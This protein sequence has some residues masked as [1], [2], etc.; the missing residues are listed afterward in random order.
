MIERPRVG[1]P[2]RIGPEGDL[3][4]FVMDEQDAV[5]I[6][7]AR[8]TSLAEAVLRAEGVR[9]AAE[10]S[11]AFV[12]EADIADL[13]QR[14]MGAEGPTDVLAF[15]IDTLDDADG[16]PV[17]VR[18]GESTG[19]DRPPGDPGDLPLLL[20]DVVVCPAVAGRNAPTHAGTLD[21]E[22]ALL[23]VHGTLHVLGYDHAEPEE[24][25]RMRARERELLEAHHWGGPAPVGFRQVHEDEA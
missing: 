18:A 12:A 25:E 17:T 11:V 20:G 5:A 13:N 14:F 21:D 4:V 19:P 1:G 22:L 8:W 23:V 24:T 7:V 16:D 2:H 9:G 6:D 10:L 3:E 15:P